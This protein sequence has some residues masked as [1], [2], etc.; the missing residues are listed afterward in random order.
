[1]TNNNQSKKGSGQPDDF[2][3]DIS[4]DLRS[5]FDDLLQTSSSTA[6][7]AEKPSEP[8]SSPVEAQSSQ[9]T[10]DTDLAKGNDMSSDSENT[11]AEEQK[12]NDGTSGESSKKAGEAAATAAFFEDDL[13]QAELAF[14]SGEFSAAPGEEKPAEGAE[15]TK[16]EAAAEE[17]AEETPAEESAV[18]AAAEEPAAEEASAETPAAEEAV[19]AAAEEASTEEPAEEESEKTAA[20]ASEEAAEEAVEAAA[21]EAPAEEPAAEEA[22]EEKA[23]EAVE[24]AAEEPTAEESSE[25]PVEEAAAEEPAAEEAVEAA[26][27]EA[28]TEEPVEEAAAEDA[29]EAAAEETAPV[30]EAAAEEPAAEEKVEEAAAEEPA[31]EA[32]V[33]EPAEEAAVEEPAEAESSGLSEKETEELAALL[34]AADGGSGNMD[35]QP[36]P[37]PQAVEEPESEEDFSASSPGTTVEA[38]GDDFTLSELLYEEGKKA[39]WEA[40]W[41]N[42]ATEEH[43]L[44]VE[45]LSAYRYK[46]G[47]KALPSLEGASYLKPKKTVEKDGKVYL[48][49]SEASGYRLADYLH[50]P[51][52]EW[53]F[54]EI[55]HIINTVGQSLSAIHKSGNLYLQL[56]GDYLWMHEN[57]D[58]YLM[59]MDRLPT[60]DTPFA[61][62]PMFEGYTA[63]EV[64]QRQGE[65]G[66]YSDIFSLGMLLHYLIGHSAKFN[67]LD[68]PS[69]DI[70]TPRVFDRRFPVGLYYII[71]KACHMDIAH[72]FQSVDEFLATFNRALEEIEYRKQKD[73]KVLELSI[74]H[75]IHIGVNKGLRSP[76]NQ[77]AL[78]WRYDRVR[79][80]GLFIVADGVSH[81]HYGSGD[82]AS[83]LVVQA[84]R[85]R[86]DT[87]IDKPIM[88]H[89]I[90]HKQ[91]S[92]LLYSIFKAAN[93]AICKEI[94]KNYDSVDGYV[95]DVMGST[96]VA[97]FI[98]GNQITFS[99]L[100]DSRI[101][102]KTSEYI[103][104]ITIDHDYKTAQMQAFQDMRAL[105]NLAGGSLITRCVGSFAKDE[106]SKILPQEM[107][108]DFFEMTL[109]PGDIILLCSDGVSDYV[110]E[111]DDESRQVI[112]HM[113][114]AYPRPLSACFWLVALANQNGGGDNI[115]LIEIKVL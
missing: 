115:S 38:D 102:L 2:F 42:K 69:P 66:P 87:L 94:N 60:K 26:A 40:S 53:S 84:A 74:G 9:N 4:Q 96:C 33:E 61:E 98:D 51:E 90:P 81:C 27:E 56:D 34:D 73:K 13:D 111:N 57:R 89:P 24:A 55:R 97:G 29:V 82:R 46:T 70:P 83:S 93:Q 80:K 77:D 114:E 106:N 92:Q 18:E 43:L 100:G 6:T 75:D 44:M 99:N 20:E 110:G 19:E 105:N 65:P 1:M 88:D 50:D 47:F 25:A 21:E 49:F 22:A 35:T 103:E 36:A 58:P 8:E 91:R 31:V 52:T 45:E 10:A 67:H 63:P 48:V 64:F 109:L 101:Y 39:I 14:F 71:E 37:P 41:A 28:S 17:K 32:A 15:E 113:L 11:A 12:A 72:R 23:E 62:R 95:E 59:N 5:E 7:K 104:Q 85:K 76:V 86:W 112:A 3:S 68:T 30:E 79:G 78:F 107:E 108:P 16:T 54:Q